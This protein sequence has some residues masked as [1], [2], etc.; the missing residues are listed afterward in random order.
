MLKNIGKKVSGFRL[1]AEYIVYIY[2]I[3]I[4]IVEA[5]RYIYA[6]DTWRISPQMGGV[7]VLTLIQNVVPLAI[8]ALIFLRVNGLEKIYMLILTALGT[9]FVMIHNIFVNDRTALAP[10]LIVFLNIYIM[11]KIFFRRSINPLK[12]SVVLMALI[13]VVSIILNNFELIGQTKTVALKEASGILII[14]SSILISY[15]MLAFRR[16][17]VFLFIAAIL[18][19][20]SLIAFNTKEAV[21]FNVLTGIVYIVS[22][23]IIDGINKKEE[24]NIKRREKIKEK[25]E[26]KNKIPNKIMYIFAIST[27]VF[28]LLY[29]YVAQIYLESTISLFS[30]SSIQIISINGIENIE[31][32]MYVLP[33]LSIIIY[34]IYFGIK[35]H[36][37]I[38]EEYIIYT[39]ILFITLVMSILYR[40]VFTNNIVT[41]ITAAMF[42]TL[43]NKIDGLK[44]GRNYNYMSVSGVNR[45]GQVI[46]YKSDRDKTREAEKFLKE[47]FGI[48][49]LRKSRKIVFGITSLG[50]GGAERVLIDIVKELQNVYDITVF[51]IYGGG[52]FEK[53][54]LGTNVKLKKIFQKPRKDYG[55]IRNI[56]NTIIFNT[57]SPIIYNLMVKNIYDVE[58]AFLEGPITRMFSQNSQA[59]KIVW[60]HTDIEKYYENEKNAEIKKK[61][62]S[63]YYS[64]YENIV[65]VSNDNLE[66]FEKVFPK[67]TVS[68]KVIYNYLDAKRIKRNAD[69][70]VAFEIEKGI[71]SLVTVARLTRVK[72]IARLLRVHKRLIDEG[73]IH[74]IYV[75]GDGEEYINLLE[76]V[77]ELGVK[78]SF[79]LLG[80][81]E[82]PYP[83]IKAADY[84]C[85]MSYVEGYGLV[86]DEAKILGKPIILTNTAAREAAKGYEKSHI[87]ENEENA[88]YA[89]LREILR[90]KKNGKKEGK[91][92]YQQQE[93]ISYSE[94]N[95]S[96]IYEIIKILDN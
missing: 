55:K 81:K 15:T 16:R 61:V 64:K 8:F 58:I 41:I 36:R 48:S 62:D 28:S 63:K 37:E 89:G 7:K 25:V 17:Y 30:K 88:I 93:K 91:V 72:G 35:K 87:L 57:L 27:I 68:K 32:V 4:G 79:R 80:K 29:G 40:E 20:A 39:Y 24:N 56:I 83:Y 44:N 53:E 18:N 33:I 23:L 47:K 13:Y 51:R 84:F 69:L 77:M 49:N 65:F 78:R 66:K 21:I 22:M 34:G 12:S 3:L 75:V 14:T 90:Q 52:E 9:G 11:Y 70:T 1:T 86:L 54:L 76:K 92:K 43:L 59:K 74:N 26:W 95:S 19:V 6:G 50:I 73:I 60:V 38:K 31:K 42:V 2:I 82:N 46:D 71:P 96:K 5:Y 85:L 45:S 10:L 94:L 67:N